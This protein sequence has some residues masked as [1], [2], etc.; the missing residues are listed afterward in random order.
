MPDLPR[1]ALPEASLHRNWG[2]GIRETMQDTSWRRKSRAGHLESGIVAALESKNQ[3][4]QAARPERDSPIQ[5]KILE[6][7]QLHER[8]VETSRAESE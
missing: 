4:S 1:A 3:G 6:V 5:Y 2:V 8:W 7:P